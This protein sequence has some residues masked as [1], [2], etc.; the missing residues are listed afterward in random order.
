M[1]TVRE[2]LDHSTFYGLNIDTSL[3]KHIPNEYGYLCGRYVQNGDELIIMDN[4]NKYLYDETNKT[5]LPFTLSSTGSSP[6]GTSPQYTDKEDIVVDTTLNSMKAN[7][8]F[9]PNA[10]NTIFT[11]RD[12][13]GKK[14]T[15]ITFLSNTSF[16]NGAFTFLDDSDN[17]VLKLPNNNVGRAQVTGGNVIDGV[18]FKSMRFESTGSAGNTYLL[19]EVAKIN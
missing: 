8:D 17:V 13:Q 5:W 15:K 6:S 9:T 7:S 19:L 14:I 4:G 18:A 2:Q 1:I 12:L 3:N 16:S 10:E 11:L